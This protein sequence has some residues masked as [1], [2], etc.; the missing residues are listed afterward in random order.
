MIELFLQILVTVFIVMDPLGAVPIFISVAGD[1]DGERKRRTIR[2]ALVIAFVV[3]AVFILGGRYILRFMGI[4]PGS[5]YVA[6]GVLF[7]LIAIDML[8]GQPK[9]A[10]TS[11]EE[12][13]EED[14]P[15]SIAVFPLAIP[16]IAGPGMITTIMLYSAGEYEP[17][18]T[19][20]ML[21]GSVLV[22][23]AAMF[24]AL[25]LSGLIL[26]AL[27]K[28]GVSVIERMMGLLL[29]GLAIQFVYDGLTKLG[30]LGRP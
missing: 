8:F 22:G 16:L 6:G 3:L 18:S 25:N 7:F 1:L 9:R 24:A 2:S 27:G 23:L 26:R 11:S 12:E 17:V 20:L 21:F 4:K 15:S 5:F 19:T 13:N 29:S 30:V 10:R 28:T 14:G